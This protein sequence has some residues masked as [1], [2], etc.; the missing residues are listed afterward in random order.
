MTISHY[1][2]LRF[3]YPATLWIS[4]I[5]KSSNTSRGYWLSLSAESEMNCDKNKLKEGRAFRDMR[6]DFL[7]RT[8][9]NGMHRNV[10]NTCIRRD[11]HPDPTAHEWKPFWRNHTLV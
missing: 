1:Q 8:T 3:C 7:G 10:L 9:R 6:L 5:F 4:Y 11:L 2:P